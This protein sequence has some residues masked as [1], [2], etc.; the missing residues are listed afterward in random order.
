MVHAITVLGE[1]VLNH[2]ASYLIC[3]IGMS[4]GL[5]VSLNPKPLYVLGA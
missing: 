1:A 4:P 5:E 2:V 3:H